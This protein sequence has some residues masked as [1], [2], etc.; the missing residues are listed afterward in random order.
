MKRIL[1]DF[2]DRFDAL[3]MDWNVIEGCIISNRFD[4]PKKTVKKM[5]EEERSIKEIESFM[6]HLHVSMIIEDVYES[7]NNETIRNQAALIYS[8]VILYRLRYKYPER[9][10]EIELNREKDDIT[11]T[12]Y[13]SNPMCQ[14][15]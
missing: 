10:F 14:K 3:W 8:A 6:N 4:S 9:N 7:R 11:I 15:H 12:Y 1:E 2:L 5:L 13:Q